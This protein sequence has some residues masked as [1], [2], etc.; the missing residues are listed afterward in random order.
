MTEAHNIDVRSYLFTA[1]ARTLPPYAALRTRCIL[2]RLAG[3]RIGRRSMIPT[4]PH[5]IGSHPRHGN[6]SIG[7]SVT[8]GINVLFDC[9]A[10]ISVRDGATIGHNAQLITGHHQIGPHEWRAGQLDPRPISIGAGSWIASGVIVL[11]GVT[12]GDGAI[13]AAGSVVTCD[14]P[15]DTLYAGAPARRIR[16]LP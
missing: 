11:P 16:D 12:I 7:D 10:P 13:V 1:I 4:V 5:F 14:V 15:S 9:A 2:L 8:L 6:L 3:W